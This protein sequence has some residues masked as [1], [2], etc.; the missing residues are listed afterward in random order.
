[1]RDWHR[2]S[3]RCLDLVLKQALDPEMRVD[4]RD[5]LFR[6]DRLRDEIHRARFEPPHALF[7]VGERGHED[8]G[9]V[10][11]LRVGFETPACL[12]AV[13]A[14][15]DDIEQDNQGSG[16]RGDPQRLLAAAGHEQAVVGTASV[17]R[18]MSRFVGSSST[19]R[20]RPALPRSALV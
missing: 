13:D 7:R 18:R 8:H 4:A 17:S 10:A 20:I 19:R 9:G 2:R 14:R 1:M 15:H 11:G 3:R 12:I 5:D 16:A 6:L